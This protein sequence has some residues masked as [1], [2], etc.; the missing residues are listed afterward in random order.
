[1]RFLVEI[2]R[3]TATRGLNVDYVHIC[4]RALE[5]F[6]D[7]LSQIEGVCGLKHLGQTVSVQSSKKVF[8][9][10]EWKGL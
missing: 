3:A 10:I 1:M 9:L 5:G 8:E 7:K 6:L 4:S 2:L